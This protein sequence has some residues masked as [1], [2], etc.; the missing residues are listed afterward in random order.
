MQIWNKQPDNLR[1]NMNVIDWILHISLI[2]TYLLN[3]VKMLLTIK[4]KM[5][6][7]MLMKSVKVFN[8][9][10]ILHG[11]QTQFWGLTLTFCT[12]E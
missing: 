1:E 6:N 7:N 5:G 4:L 2:T 12:N 9:Q 10:A 11:L 3:S 8:F